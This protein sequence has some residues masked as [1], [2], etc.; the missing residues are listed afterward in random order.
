MIGHYYCVLSD[1]LDYSV[2]CQVMM[3]LNLLSEENL[4]YCAKMYSDYQKNVFLLDQL[5]VADTPS[6]NKF[7]Q[8]LK[9]MKCQKELGHMLVNGT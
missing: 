2:I 6:I 1:N 9:I 4:V 5:L 7:C 8:L 3:E